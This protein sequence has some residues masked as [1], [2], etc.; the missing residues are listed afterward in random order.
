MD[1]ALRALRAVPHARLCD[2]FAL[3]G[4]LCFPLLFF[5]SAPYGKLHRAGW[6]PALS[7]RWGWFLQEIVSP[8]TL[9]AAYHATQAAEAPPAADAS[10][11]SPQPVH[12]LLA[13]W[14]AHYANRAVVYPLQR[15]MGAT[16]VPVVAAAIA[17]NVVNGGLVGAELSRASRGALASW[18]ALRAPRAL[19]GLSLFLGGAALNVRSDAALRALRAAAP[20]RSYHIPRGG[21][22]ELVACP[23]YLGEILEW[24]GFAVATS[25]RSAAVFAFW[26]AANLAPRAWATRAWYRHKFRE[27]YPRRRRALVPFLF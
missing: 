6:G 14:C 16:T 20:P 25:L 11:F 13:L 22:F 27:D 3:S 23:H 2:A 18:D 10:A 4:A 15:A 26:T 12:L 9:L 7:G 19:A 8:I 5:V 17:F 21:L 24:S 1:A